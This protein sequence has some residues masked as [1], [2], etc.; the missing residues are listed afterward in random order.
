MYGSALVVIVVGP[1]PPV[2]VGKLARGVAHQK[3]CLPTLL[4]LNLTTPSG[5]MEWAVVWHS[6]ASIIAALEVINRDDQY[7][8]TYV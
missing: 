8:H 4:A 7:A 3:P 2:K 6:H 1:R 5:S